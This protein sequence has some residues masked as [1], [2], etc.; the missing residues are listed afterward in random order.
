MKITKRE[1][2]CLEIITNNG[3]I[4]LTRLS[5]TLGVKP[6]TAY[7]LVKK[8]TK[9]GMV[10]RSIDGLIEA[11]A[12][13]R[14]EAEGIKFRHRVMETLLARNGVDLKEACSECDKLDFVISDRTAAEIFE[15]LHKPGV[16]PHGK[17]IRQSYR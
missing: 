12:A 8:L 14:K 9:S 7:I 11:T 4:K 5:K 2:D 16:C 17:P 6:S 15:K 13:G 3:S 1:R 10:K